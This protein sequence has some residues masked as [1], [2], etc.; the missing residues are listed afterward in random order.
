MRVFRSLSAKV[1]EGRAPQDI[2]ADAQEYPYGDVGARISVCEM[3]A[4]DKFS[5]Y[6]QKLDAEKYTKFAGRLITD[7]VMD[8]LFAKGV[9]TSV[10]ASGVTTINNSSVNVDGSLYTGPVGTGSGAMPSRITRSGEYMN[11]AERNVDDF[12]ER[13]VRADFYVRGNVYSGPVA[14]GF[15]SQ[16]H[17]Y[18]Y[19]VKHEDPLAELKDILEQLTAGIRDADLADSDD[20]V[21]D[22]DRIQGEIIRKK[23]DRARIK[24]LMER[25]TRV[26]APTSSLLA[27]AVNARELINLIPH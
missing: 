23:P 12:S 4:I 24:E 3:G 16:A 14:N 13:N 26:V 7:T 10:Y 17:Q 11:D 20:A 22:I 15:K 21:E 19:D 6:I 27:I 2:A 8:F 18:N 5:T 25:V 9:D 1:Q